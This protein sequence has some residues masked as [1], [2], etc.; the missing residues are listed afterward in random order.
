MTILS[1][2]FEVTL[3][4]TLA[5]IA[6]GK[7]LQYLFIC[8][9]KSTIASFIDNFPWE[10]GTKRQQRGRRDS[11]DTGEAA[12]GW[13]YFVFIALP[14]DK[15]ARPLWTER[16]TSSATD[17]RQM[18]RTGKIGQFTS[19]LWSANWRNLLLI[20]GPHIF[21]NSLDI[22]LLPLRRIKDKDVETVDFHAASASI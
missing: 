7:K 1:F 3:F 13:M 9:W 4:I 16:C 15:E 6:D 5:V 20:S 18:A 12:G 17:I 8:C 22:P 14:C 19:V 10:N 2:K 11:R 21:E